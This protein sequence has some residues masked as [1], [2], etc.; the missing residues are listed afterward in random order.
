MSVVENNHH[1]IRVHGFVGQEFWRGSVEGSLSR[2][3]SAV[4][5]WSCVQLQVG[6]S[7]DP[8]QMH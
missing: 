6:W 5:T 1:V 8:G 3:A 7:E 2:W 4:V